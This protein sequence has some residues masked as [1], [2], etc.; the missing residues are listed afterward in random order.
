WPVRPGVM[1][2]AYAMPD[3][4][5][6]DGKPTFYPGSY[7]TAGKQGGHPFGKYPPLDDHFYFLAAVHAHWKLTRD[8]AI[9]R[10]LAG[11]LAEK[12]YAVAPSDAATG[13]VTAGDTATENA[14]DW[15]FCDTIF[16]SGKLLFP[17]VLKF[18]AARQLAEL[19]D[20][21]GQ[22]AKA[23]RYR[24]EAGKLRRAIGRT[25]LNQDGWLHSATEVGNQ[26][27]V[28]GSAFAVWAGAVDQAAADRVA[29][30]LVRAYRDKTAVR[31][32]CVRHLPAGVWQKTI[33]APG[34]YQN[35]G[36][37]GT[38]SG[39]YIAAI[40]RADP[41]AARDM[42]QDF[43]RFVRTSPQWEWFNPDT[44]QH[45]NPQYVATVALPYIS[46][47]EAGLVSQ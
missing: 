35:G 2:P 31:E 16:K 32:G 14:K 20:A 26:P 4:I 44:G 47:I 23:V 5:N 29:R 1:V 33:A 25:F 19:F 7:E 28:W 11:D 36:Y 21:A 12:V 24:R 22:P 46:L 39:W 37:W 41:Q 3:T 9:F 18:R 17:S 15:G 38:P 30:T 10:E 42:A 43:L 6:F 45:A 27:D 40:H 34:T 13:L 8:P